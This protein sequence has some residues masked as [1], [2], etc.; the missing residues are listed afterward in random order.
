MSAPQ[1]YVPHR[2]LPCYSYVPGMFPHPISHVDGH[3]RG[4]IDKPIHDAEDGAFGFDLFNHG[5]YWE[6][7]EAWE[8]GW[9]VLGRKG[10][11]ADLCK[12]LIKLAAAGVKAREGKPEGVRRHA[13][14]AEELLRGC[15]ECESENLSQH[16]RDRCVEWAKFAKAVYEDADGYVDTRED[17]VVRVFDFT[18]ELPEPG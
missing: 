6:A 2:Q 4:M 14:R 10:V 8:Q 17:P 12:G 15:A 13:R 11:E 9:I 1:R 16:E 5:Y 7:H 18:L 3:M